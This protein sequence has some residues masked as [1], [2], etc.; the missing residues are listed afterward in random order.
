MKAFSRYLWLLPAVLFV[1]VAAC[2]SSSAPRMPQPKDTDETQPPDTL[3]QTGS[4]AAALVHL[5]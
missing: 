1:V 2:E 5:A 3:P 4:A